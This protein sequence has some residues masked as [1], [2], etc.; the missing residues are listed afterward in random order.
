MPVWCD[1]F[2]VDVRV[3][4]ERLEH[5]RLHRD[6]IGWEDLIR[7]T[8]LEPDLVVSSTHGEGIR[9]YDKRFADSPVGDKRLWV[10][11]KWHPQD[12]FLVTAYFTDRRGKGTQLWP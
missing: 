12:A 8:L 3:S 1:V 11:V 2:G 10:I 4:E 6:L 9:I 7:I 5:L